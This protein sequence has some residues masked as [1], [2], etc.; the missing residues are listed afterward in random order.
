MKTA[1]V[2]DEAIAS[3]RRLP[4]DATLEDLQYRLY[5]LEKIRNAEESLKR[6]GGISHAEFKSRMRK[7][8]TK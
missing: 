4:K 8:L 7:W 3:L 2:R 6:N 5:V 1:N